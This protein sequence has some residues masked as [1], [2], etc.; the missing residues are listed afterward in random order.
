MG[1]IDTDPTFTPAPVRI[2]RPLIEAF[3]RSPL[4]PPEHRWH[5][6]STLPVLAL[7]VAMTTDESPRGLAWEELDPEDLLAASLDAEPEE[8]AFLRDLLD[9]S[10]SFYAFLASERV[11]GAARGR[12]VRR[13]LATLALGL[14]R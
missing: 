3:C 9:V 4:C 7:F 13:A 11:I 6:R 12:E 5:A 8:H 10:G 2:A 14:S 1:F